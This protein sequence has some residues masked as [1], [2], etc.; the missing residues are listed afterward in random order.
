MSRKAGSA[1]GGK[2]YLVLLPTIV[3]LAAGCHKQ[4]VVTKT[5]APQATTTQ[6]VSLDPANTTAYTDAK[7]KFTFLTP[8]NVNVVDDNFVASSS[9]AANLAVGVAVTDFASQPKDVAAACA[10]AKLPAN[11]TGPR[12]SAQPEYL[13][14]KQAFANKDAAYL[15]QNFTGGQI[16]FTNGG[17]LIFGYSTVT[18]KFETQF[19]IFDSSNNLIRVNSLT[20]N[21]QTVQDLQAS[22]DYQVMQTVSESFKF[23]N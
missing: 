12:D 16:T 21:S 1:F 11:C 19:D 3:L 18:K 2:K 9:T 4:P 14:L 7:Y 15:Q 23:N 17:A 22:P 5:P 20:G 8:K 6:Q 13:A 10:K